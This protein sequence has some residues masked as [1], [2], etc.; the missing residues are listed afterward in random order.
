MRLAITAIN[1]TGWA[2]IKRHYQVVFNTGQWIDIDLLP[3]D[4]NTVRTTDEINQLVIKKSAAA[5]YEK[6]GNQLTEGNDH[7]IE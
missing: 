7:A 4:Y 3:S 5:F 2:A 1:Q 6:Y